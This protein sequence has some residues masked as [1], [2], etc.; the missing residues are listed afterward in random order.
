MLEA[1]LF[2]CAGD[3]H[4]HLNI[5]I[6]GKDMNQQAGQLEALLVECVQL[7]LVSTQSRGT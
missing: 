6:K 4:T 7:N 5:L 1:G 2:D 3:V